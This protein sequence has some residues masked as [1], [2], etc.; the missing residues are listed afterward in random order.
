MIKK[1]DYDSFFEN[2]LEVLRDKLKAEL[3]SRIDQ[4]AEREFVVG[5]IMDEINSTK[6]SLTNGTIG[7]VEQPDFYKQALIE[8]FN[9]C[10]KSFKDRPVE[11]FVTEELP[12]IKK[13]HLNKIKEGYVYGYQLDPG[14]IHVD[15]HKTI[16]DF[17]TTC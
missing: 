13:E 4:A 17:I 10:L 9:D 7:D 16:L 12:E 3:Q 15:D 5:K 2:N 6:H 1:I 14:F 8:G 11:H